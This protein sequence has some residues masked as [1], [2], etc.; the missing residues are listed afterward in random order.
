MVVNR[1]LFGVKTPIEE[2]DS[3]SFQI[4]QSVTSKTDHTSMG[5]PLPLGHVSSLKN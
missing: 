2:S 4:P 3:L 5:L 1:I